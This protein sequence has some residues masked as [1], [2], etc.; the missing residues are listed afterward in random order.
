MAFFIGMCVE[1]SAMMRDMTLSIRTVNARILAANV[2]AVDSL[3]HRMFA[4][5][6]EFHNDIIEY[7]FLL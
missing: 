3:I 7:A 5:C 1:V 6:V 4:E 2:D